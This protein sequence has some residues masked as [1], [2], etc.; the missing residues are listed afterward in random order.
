MALICLIHGR[1]GAG[2]DRISSLD[3]TSAGDTGGAGSVLVIGEP[4]RAGTTLSF[5][6]ALLKSGR[7]RTVPGLLSGRRRTAC[8][9]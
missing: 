3:T 7:A 2:G 6:W 5:P 9:K 4:Q 1:G 8:C